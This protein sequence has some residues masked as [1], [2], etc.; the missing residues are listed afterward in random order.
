MVSSEEFDQWPDLLKKVTSYISEVSI[1]I[2]I[3]Y[4]NK[5]KYLKNM[6]SKIIF[7]VAPM[8]MAKQ[9]TIYVNEVAGGV[10]LCNINERYAA[11]AW[12]DIAPSA[13][14]QCFTQLVN[15][16]LYLISVNELDGTYTHYRLYQPA[17]D[18]IP[19]TQCKFTGYPL[20]AQFEYECLIHN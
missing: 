4:K 14:D 17:G 18:E 12:L 13:L 20:D 11:L 6:L 1:R 5:S 16:Q 2:F 7:A 10:E 15:G 3:N 19:E 8:A 9:T